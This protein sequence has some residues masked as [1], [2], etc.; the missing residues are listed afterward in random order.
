MLASL[1][2]REHRVI[3]AIAVIE[4]SSD[5]ILTDICE[6]P[7]M[8]RPYGEA[9]LRAY[10]ESDAPL[11]KAG[12]YGIQDELFKP[13]DTTAMRECYANVMGLPLCHLTR[14]LRR[15]GHEPSV[16]I[17]H[18]C[19]EYTRYPCQVFAGILQESG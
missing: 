7:V 12:G 5:R 9:E 3:T 4:R 17:A 6:T 10:V 15:L 13:V 2:D 18:A 1:R 11:D 14:T 8:M 16:D 19:R